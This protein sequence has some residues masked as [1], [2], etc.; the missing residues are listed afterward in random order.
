MAEILSNSKRRS[1]M[2]VIKKIQ[3]GFTL[4][5]LMIVVAIIGILAAIALPQYGNYTSRTKA[6]GAVAELDSLRTAMSECFQ[7]EG[8]WTGGNVECATM[9]TATIPQVAS[10]K[11][12]VGVPTVTAGSGVIAFTSAATTSSGTA[13]VGTYTP[14]AASTDAN[15]VW[16]LGATTICDSV[17]GLKPGQ[18][19]C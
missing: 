9:G 18:G 4:I 19:G 16:S 8:K 7:S 14:T 1:K 11:F 12:I 15:M 10:T 5:E 6:A 17:R 2:K 13:L 3:S